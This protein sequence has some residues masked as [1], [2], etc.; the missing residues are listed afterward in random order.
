MA[1]DKDRLVEVTVAKRRSIYLNGDQIPGGKPGQ[2][3]KFVGPGEKAMV[4]VSDLSRMV[5]QGFILDPHAKKLTAD[6]IAAADLSAYVPIGEEVKITEN[7]DQSI[8][9]GRG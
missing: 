2:P 6:E 9:K 5:K 7:S 8:K 3:G 1:E 4:P